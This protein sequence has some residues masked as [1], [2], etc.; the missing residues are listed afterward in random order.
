MSPLFPAIFIGGP[1]HAGKSTL[2]YR[3]SHALRQQGLGHYAL[4][5][6]PDG[7]GDWSLE[8]PKAMVRELRL[9]T[10][11]CWS[12]HFADRIGRDIDQRHLPLLVDAGGKVSSYNEQ[13]AAAC[14]HGLLLAKQ[15]DDFVSWRDL[16][17]RQG[18]PIIAELYSTQESIQQIDDTGPVLRGTICGLGHGLSSDG[19]CFDAVVER[20]KTYF[21][22]DPEQ[23]YYTHAR[24]AKVDLVLHL[25]R[26]LPP[27]PV[28]SGENKWKPEELPELLATLPS[29]EPLALYGRGP[30]W[31]SGA[32]A[33]FT[34]PPPK[35]FHAL[36]GWVTP[37][38]LR[39]S[40]IADNERLRWEKVE[41]HDDATYLRFA[42][43]QNYLDH[44]YAHDLPVPQVDPTRGVILSGKLPIWLYVALTRTY[45]HTA[46]I[47]I[48]QPQ[49]GNVIVW[50]QIDSIQVGDLY[51]D[52]PN[53]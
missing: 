31:L 21:N 8:A 4:R 37:P 10:K 15:P 26:E 41:E 39:P 45:L 27:L 6:S 3:L 44:E 18:R 42:I 11:G 52:P 40:K 32:I 7:E 53:S 48:F 2:L 1:P 9:S 20:L 29:T 25:E 50:S 23:L 22:Y 12:D 38:T 47:A 5:A 46:W 19:V 51:D 43:P 17:A 49:E 16:L 14:T 28:H 13:I 35:L 24:L 36:V 33:A 30:A 34:M